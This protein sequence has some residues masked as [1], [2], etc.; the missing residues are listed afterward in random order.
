MAEH[1]RRLHHIGGLAQ[2]LAGSAPFHHS[3]REVFG[4]EVEVR[5][6]L[7]DDKLA[8][9]DEQVTMV[10]ASAQPPSES[11][12]GV[13]AADRYALQ[14]EVARGGMGIIYKVRD[15]ELNRT[16]AMKVML[17]GPPATSLSHRM[18]EARGE[19]F[20]ATCGTSHP[21]LTR[22]LEEVQVTAQLD[23]PGIVAVHEL[24]LDAAGRPYFTMKLV[25]GRGLGRIFE[26]ARAEQ[27]GWNLPRAIGALIKACQAVAFAHTKGVIH[28]DLKPA[29]VMVGRFGEVYVMDWGLAKV[30][31]RK[32]L[33]DL[34]LVP[35]SPTTVTEIQTPRGASGTST[36]DSP[37]ITMDGSV[38]GTPAYMPPEQA[39][40]QVEQV[41]ALSDVYSLGAILYNLL[42]GQAPYVEPSAHISPHT[43]LGMVIQG[44]PKRIHTLNPKVPAELV[45]ICEKAMAREKRD[46]YQS[47]LDLGEDLQAWLD[48]RVV[49]AYRTGAVA[50]LKSWVARNKA[51]AS[52][53]VV[54]ALL[55]AIGV[56][57]FIAQQR[58]ANARLRLHAY[59]SDMNLAENAL[60]VNNVGRAL[61]LLDH[62]RPQPGEPDLRGWEWRY[63]WQRCRSDALYTLTRHSDVVRSLSFSRDGRLLAI[64]AA[65]GLIELWDIGS[66]QLITTLQTN[67]Q[68]ATVAF[69]PGTNLLAATAQRGVV[70]L[71]DATTRT[72]LAQ[73]THGGQVR[74]LAFSPDGKMLAIF[75][76]DRRL[77]LWELDTASQVQTIP[78]MV[79]SGWH[80]GCVAF[81]PDNHSLAIGERDGTIRV[82]DVRTVKETH[83]FAAHRQGITALMFSADGKFLVSGAAYSDQT[84]RVWNLAAGTLES[85]LEGH[86]AWI[87]GFGLAPDG[88]VFASSAADQTLRLWDT[89]SWKEL[90]VLRGHSDEVAAIAFSP[91]GHTIASGSRDGSVLLWDASRRQTSAPRASFPKTL[92]AAA[93]LGDG[94]TIG[95]LDLAG[96][97]SLW[98]ART[99]QETPLFS[100][101]NAFVDL[102][103]DGKAL[104]Y[105]R[106]NTLQVWDVTSH[107]HSNLFQVPV[108]PFIGAIKYSAERKLLAFGSAAGNVRLLPT[109]RPDAP[110]QLPSHGTNAWPIQFLDKGAKL[111]TLDRRRVMKLWDVD[112]RSELGSLRLPEDVLLGEISA[113]GKFN[114]M[115]T[116]GGEI[117]VWQMTGTARKITTMVHKGLITA[118]AFSPAGRLLVTATQKGDVKVWEVPAGRERLTLR[119]HLLGVHSVVFSPDGRRLATGSG[120]LEAIKLWDLATFQEVATL[121]AE[122]SLVRSIQFSEGGDTILA[123]GTNENLWHV[124]HAPALA[125]ID[126]AEKMR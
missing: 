46:R 54:V 88:K 30:T 17:G 16:L 89:A 101:T 117:M 62:H 12:P 4:E 107:V 65:D 7:D 119:G 15:R 20:P 121:D 112:R 31:G 43:I 111:L 53:A 87:C 45:A 77:T 113:D 6:T 86:T 9:E 98:D 85:K 120:G 96:G 13:P 57:L 69:A 79:G 104:V 126:A 80:Y 28:R 14:G 34:R 73:F 42:T 1:L 5:L 40:G 49:K 99:M 109:D 106:T 118:M 41:D 58:R 8:A 35:A 38:V 76:Q 93:L 78:V 105:D 11:A 67:G 100:L 32:D 21:L 94:R 64:G 91:D 70:I 56:T 47:S 55:P 29:N 25:K 48:H 26:L 95:T 24:G 61:R 110:A 72:E 75:G 114:A 68:F 81:S 122:G 84:I 44:P 63:M 74:T 39:R 36:A 37:L 3:L 124:W 51:V 115:A 22:F 125:E 33:H 116:G 108:G 123:G 59:A 97:I 23:H 60:R 90:A 50:E 27:E 19:G 82:M 71:W 10:D 92:R 102:T 52:L 66:R 103:S 83:R 2:S 18:G